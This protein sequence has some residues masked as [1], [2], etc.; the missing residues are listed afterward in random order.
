MNWKTLHCRVLPPV[1][2]AAADFA[3]LA[4]DA[5]QR[6]AVGD[7]ADAEAAKARG[8]T[9]A[10]RSA[11][12]EYNPAARDVFDKLHDRAVEYA[13]SGEQL[14]DRLRFLCPHRIADGVVLQLG[15]GQPLTTTRRSKSV[16]WPCNPG[17][18]A[19]GLHEA[20]TET[21]AAGAALDGGAA[22]ALRVLNH[23]T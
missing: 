8:H 13:D 11:P 9:N 12:R 2:R 3:S 5:S 6:P 1:D 21:L 19:G 20:V 7:T 18:H 15:P 23:E 4:G 16:P 10:P 14:V 22:A 17:T